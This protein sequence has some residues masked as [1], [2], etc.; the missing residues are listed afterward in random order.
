[1]RGLEPDAGDC[2]RASKSTPPFFVLCS[3]HP[4]LSMAVGALLLLSAIFLFYY[5]MDL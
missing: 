3:V 4:S 5:V 1:M 2:C